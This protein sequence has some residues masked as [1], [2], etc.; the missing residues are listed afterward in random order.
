[1]FQLSRV[2]KLLFGVSAVATVGS[3]CYFK[4]EIFGDEDLTGAEIRAIKSIGFRK[5]YFY[6]LG[7]LG[8]LY[9]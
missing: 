7:P 3:T 9:N 2:S 8:G 5:E 4:D 1:M 6:Q